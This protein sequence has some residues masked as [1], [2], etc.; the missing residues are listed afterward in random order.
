M[1]KTKEDFLY[2]GEGYVISKDEEEQFKDN[3][4]TWL[5]NQH[6][7]QIGDDNGLQGQKK[8][9]SLDLDND[10]DI[11]GDDAK[12]A[13]KVMNAVRKKKRASRKKKAKN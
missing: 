7:E 3:I 1:Y 13:S 2:W 4:P 6:I 12:I 8:E 11:D 9:I 5:K 10:G